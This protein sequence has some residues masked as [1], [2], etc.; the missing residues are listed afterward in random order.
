MPATPYQRVRR[1]STDCHLLVG[2]S[3]H[4]AWE[5]RKGA[6]RTH[7][8]EAEVAPPIV[9][10]HPKPCTTPINISTKIHIDA[11][12]TLG[13]GPNHTDIHM[14]SARTLLHSLQH[15]CPCVGAHPRLGMV[16]S[17]YTY[18]SVHPTLCN[19]PNHLHLPPHRGTQTS[20]DLLRL[21]SVCRLF[22]RFGEKDRARLTARWKVSVGFR[23]DRP[24]PAALPIGRLA[25][26]EVGV[27]N[28]GLCWLKPVLLQA[29]EL[30]VAGSGL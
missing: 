15:P 25:D 29:R 30:G 1:L 10:V 24:K 19:T 8:D 17:P 6:K 12:H 11:H 3:N 9:R 28:S 20:G 5:W 23:D 26:R 7:P 27:P 16:Q 18:T 13:N 4:S 22:P 2:L 14:H 21:C